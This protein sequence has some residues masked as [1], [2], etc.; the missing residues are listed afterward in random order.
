MVVWS[1]GVK[2]VMGACSLVGMWGLCC[3]MGILRCK[4][5]GLIVSGADSKR[6]IGYVNE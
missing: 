5:L 3:V 4:E 1:I 6:V 2:T